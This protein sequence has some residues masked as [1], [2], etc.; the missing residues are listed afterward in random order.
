MIL[1][2]VNKNRVGRSETEIP[3]GVF[4]SVGLPTR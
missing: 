2:H 4:G 1:N 3:N